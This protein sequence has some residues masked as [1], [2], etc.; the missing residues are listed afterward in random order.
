MRA[1]ADSVG[2]EAST[3]R[4]DQE[5][6][7]ICGGSVEHGDKVGRSQLKRAGSAWVVRHW[8]SVAVRTGRVLE[9]GEVMS[10]NF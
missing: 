2:D 10:A 1:G 8:D 3:T 9:I 4:G 7:D 5:G 6:V